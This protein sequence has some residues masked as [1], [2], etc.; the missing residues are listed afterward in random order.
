MFREN[1]TK[2]KLRSGQPVFGVIGPTG[3]PELAEIVGLCGYDFYLLDAEHGSVTPREAANV[4]RA[5]EA[6]DITP[7]VR[8]GTRDPKTI[9]QYLDAGMMGIMSPDCTSVEQV[10]ALV[11]AIKYPP[12]GERGLGAARAARYLLGP[13]PQADYVAAANRETIV[14]PQLEDA[15]ALGQ[16]AEIVAVAGI[17]GLVIGPRDLA[18]NMGFPDGPNHA[19]VQ[20]VIDQ[21]LETCRGRIPVGTTAATAEAANVELARGAR[22]LFNSIPNLLRHGARTFLDGVRR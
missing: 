6:V 22:I 11:R 16:L 3:D 18:L 13:M 15:A 8:V 14:W 1:R 9:L 2:A 17:D 19:E 7:L 5:C 10:R 12:D 20:A 4:A 21:V